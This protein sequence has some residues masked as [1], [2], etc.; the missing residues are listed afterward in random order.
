V[1]APTKLTRGNER[2][3]T[4]SGRNTII[5]MKSLSQPQSGTFSSIRQKEFHIQVKLNTISASLRPL[6]KKKMKLSYAKMASG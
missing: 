6:P 4:L 3:V 5:F 2:L 1:K